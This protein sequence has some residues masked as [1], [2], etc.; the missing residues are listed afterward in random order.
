VQPILATKEKDA[1]R[2]AEL[3][4]SIVDTSAPPVKALIGK[5]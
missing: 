2:V 1:K 3:R 4:T 5:K